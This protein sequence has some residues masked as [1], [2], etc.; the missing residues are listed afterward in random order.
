MSLKDK[1]LQHKETTEAAQKK[2]EAKWL[3]WIS[4]VEALMH[5]IE[6]TVDDAVKANVLTKQK[7]PMEISDEFLGKTFNLP[8]LVLIANGVGVQIQVATQRWAE[9]GGHVEVQGGAVAGRKHVLTW[10]GAGQSPANWTISSAPAGMVASSVSSP[11]R[12]GVQQNP[13]TRE[14]LEE[15]L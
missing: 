13:L 10:D 6:N 12:I 11:G 2:I 5:F 1:L 9:K 4:A 14:A 8:Q 15:A 7:T 3:T